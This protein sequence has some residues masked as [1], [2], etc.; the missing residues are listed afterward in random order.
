M[1]LTEST[2]LAAARAASLA[3]Q[4]LATLPESARNDALT[5]LHSA[6]SANKNTILEAN[7]RDLEAASSAA[8][9]GRLS[10]SV[11]KRL[12]LARPGKFEDMLNGVLDVRGLDDPS[13]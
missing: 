10:Q 11:F 2:P 9:D 7:A 4:T 6:L 1:S 13:K 8:A 12:D 3:S 5:E